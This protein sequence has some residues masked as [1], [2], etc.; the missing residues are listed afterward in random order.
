MC[1]VHF[2]VCGVRCAVCG[3]R[4][5]VTHSAVTRRSHFSCLEAESLPD[6]RMLSC[7]APKEV[8]PPAKSSSGPERA[9]D[10]EADLRIAL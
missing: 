4:C 10:A 9:N 7:D 8:M 2:A 6:R 3:V 5:A 1:N